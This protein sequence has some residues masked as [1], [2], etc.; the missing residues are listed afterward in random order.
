MAELRRRLKQ[1]REALYIYYSA[2]QEQSFKTLRN[3]FVVFGI[4]LAITLFSNAYLEA[5][6]KQELLVLSGLIICGIG[7]FIAMRAYMR[8]VISRIVL[9]FSDDISK[10]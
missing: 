3:G 4:G 7:F 5:T 1:A 9:F 6:A 10:K 2:P 8:L